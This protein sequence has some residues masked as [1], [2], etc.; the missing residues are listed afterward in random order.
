MPLFQSLSFV[1]NDQ[2]R[3]NA[4]DMQSGL[5]LRSNVTQALQVIN[6]N[7]NNIIQEQDV[8]RW[9]YANWGVEKVTSEYK[10][11]EIK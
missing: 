10:P 9:G 8:L 4:I 7:K 3:Q 2:I 6:V 1:I 5:T 11:Q